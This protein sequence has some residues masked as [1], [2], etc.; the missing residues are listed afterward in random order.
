M[1]PL[2]P[3]RIGLTEDKRRDIIDA[4]ELFNPSVVWVE[5]ATPG[6]FLVE[7]IGEAGGWIKRNG[8]YVGSIKRV[9]KN[10]L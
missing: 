9:K 1:E 3:G 5:L 8:L 10:E 7:G 2:F 4:I 6:P